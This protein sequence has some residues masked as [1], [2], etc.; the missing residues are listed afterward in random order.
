MKY[1]YFKL[2]NEKEITIVRFSYKSYIEKMRICGVFKEF[3]PTNAI[4]R[5]VCK[6]NGLLKIK[7]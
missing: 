6:A 1:S 2:E 7:S 5:Q 3:I 4:K